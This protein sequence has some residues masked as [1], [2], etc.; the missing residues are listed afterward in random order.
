MAGS[1]LERIP[2]VGGLGYVERVTAAAVHIHRHARARSLTTAIFVMP[3]L[4]SLRARRW[5]MW[6][7]K[8]RVRY[9]APLLAA[10]A[11]L[12][13]AGPPGGA[14]RS[15]I[16]GRGASARLQC[17]V[18][19]TD[20][21]RSAVAIVAAGL[22][23]SAGI[24]AAPDRSSECRP[25]ASAHTRPSPPDSKPRARSKSCPSWTN[26]GAWPAIP[27][28]THQSITSVSACSTP[29]LLRRRMPEVRSG[30]TNFRTRGTAGITGSARSPSL[31]MGREGSRCCLAIG[32]ECHSRSIPFLP[33]REAFVPGSSIWPVRARPTIK[34]RTLPERS[35]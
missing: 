11:P 19:R 22:L 21:M 13:C 7:R 34:V 27:G 8:W 15:R 24:G 17:A 23:L 16:V 31:T 2:V 29:D 33:R 6:P 35:C 20:R 30:S 10:P 1:V 28:S 4:F 18:G 9:F 26:T 32:I 12:I 14:V 5:G 3:L 25:Q